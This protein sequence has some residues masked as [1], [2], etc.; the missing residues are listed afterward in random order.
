MML[1][2]L[3]RMTT[4]L[5]HNSKVAKTIEIPGILIRQDGINV[6]QIG[7]GLELSPSTGH[8]YYLEISPQ[9]E[10][11]LLQVLAS[12]AAMRILQSL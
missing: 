10:A 6:D 3:F 11:A 9:D 2:K 4:N 7:F 8:C 1:S 5:A 12:R